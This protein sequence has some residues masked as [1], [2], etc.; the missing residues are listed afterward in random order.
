MRKES[1]LV[2]ALKKSHRKFRVGDGSISF[3]TQDI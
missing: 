2:N 1:S 3:Y